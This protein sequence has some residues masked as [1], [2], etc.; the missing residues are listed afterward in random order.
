MKAVDKFL[1]RMKNA[2]EK[3]KY[4][5]KGTMLRNYDPSPAK[6]SKSGSKSPKPKSKVF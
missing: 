4:V 6:R 1:E 2:Q 5:E 3:K